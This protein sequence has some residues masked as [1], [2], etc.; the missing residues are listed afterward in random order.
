MKY[1]AVGEDKSL[2][3][4]TELV[5]ALAGGAMSGNISFE[6]S[7]STSEIIRFLDNNINTYGNGISI[8][9]GGVTVIGGGEAAQ[10]LEGTVPADTERVM[11]GS[12]TTIEF[13][14]NVQSGVANAKKVT[15]STAGLFSGHQKAITSG[16]AA[17]S[18]GSNGDIYI[19][20]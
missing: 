9:G 11:I 12:D 6:G 8:G 14:T 19:Q 2:V 17:P 10:V 16:T 13:Y 20:Y 7:Q 5:L 1:F 15:L 4:V 3:D 18:G